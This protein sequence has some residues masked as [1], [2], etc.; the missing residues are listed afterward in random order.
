MGYSESLEAAGAKVIAYEQFGSYQ[1]DWGAYVELNGNKY[2]ITGSYG[3][4]SGCDAFEAEFG[5]TDKPYEHNGKYFYNYE[6][7]SK[8]VFEEKNQEY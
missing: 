2:I 6:E 4:C 1:G 7:C 5:Y 8:E 3:S